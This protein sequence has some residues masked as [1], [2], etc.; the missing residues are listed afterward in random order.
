M[1]IPRGADNLGKGKADNVEQTSHLRWTDLVTSQ[2]VVMSV[3]Q[4]VLIIAGDKL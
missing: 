2:E 4:K 3:P 1:I